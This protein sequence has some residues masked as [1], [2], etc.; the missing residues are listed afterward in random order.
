MINK[1]TCLSAHPHPAIDLGKWQNTVNLMADLYG[2]VCGAVVQLRDDEFNVI[3]TS[4]S[5]GNFLKRDSRWNWDAK[6]FCRRVVE[7]DSDLYESDP[8][9]NSQWCDAD[10]VKLGPVRSYLGVP[11]HWPDKQIFG[12][13]CV[14][15]TQVTSYDQNLVRLLGQLAILIE[16]D[17]QHITDFEE[18][19]SL[20]LQD[21][22]TGIYNRR[23]FTTLAE[24][25]LKT[26]AL[27]QQETALVFLDIDNLKLINDTFGHRAGDKLIVALAEC[28]ASHVRETNLYAR[29]G[30]DEFVMYFQNMSQRN[31]SLII[32]KISYSF[33]K[34]VNSIDPTNSCAAGFSFGLKMY[35]IG[36]K[37]SL[38]ERFEQADQMMYAHK[39]YKK[40]RARKT[41]V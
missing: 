12:T 4:E 27:L 8:K 13:I 41:S 14:I 11:V 32:D 20:A 25:Y 3:S 21:G 31:I 23:G 37:N 17:L 6:T 1:A 26:A 38:I 28:I 16:A 39:A 29:L 10:P 9:N 7:S 33:Q 22:L 30:G 15:D 19:K 40:S 35:P 18:I 2:S 5:A 36:A 34:V 24:E